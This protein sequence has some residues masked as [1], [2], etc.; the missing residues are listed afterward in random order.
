MTKIIFLRLL[1]L[2]DAAGIIALTL[3]VILASHVIMFDHTHSTY[4]VS[5]GTA[6]RYC[7]L[8]LNVPGHGA[9]GGGLDEWC[10][11]GN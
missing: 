8:E 11:S 1:S 7:S 2:A 4:G 9:H 6:T 5:I 10:Q 3:A